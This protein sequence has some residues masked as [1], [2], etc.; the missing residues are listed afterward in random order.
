MILDFIIRHDR[1]G[2]LERFEKAPQHGFFVNSDRRNLTYTIMA[3]GD[4]IA[5]E[6][7][8]LDRGLGRIFYFSAPREQYG[9]TIGNKDNDNSRMITTSR[10]HAPWHFIIVLLSKHSTPS[11][12][13]LRLIQ[14]DLKFTFLLKCL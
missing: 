1:D 3:T 5:L 4:D 8:R 10:D 9:L 14:T 7:G 2:D 12:I 6:D 13:G 11:K